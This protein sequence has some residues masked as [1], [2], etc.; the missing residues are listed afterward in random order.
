MAKFC[1]QNCDRK[2]KRITNTKKNL[3]SSSQTKK[4]C[5]TALQFVWI[6]YPLFH[7]YNGRLQKLRDVENIGL[8]IKDKI[9]LNDGT[10]KTVSNKNLKILKRYEGLPLSCNVNYENLKEKYYTVINS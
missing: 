5:T 3:K 4:E 2:E 10:Y 8:Q 6:R 9:Y 1:K 7:H